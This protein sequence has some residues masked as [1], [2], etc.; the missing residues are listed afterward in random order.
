MRLQVATSAPAIP[1]FMAKRDRSL[2]LSNGVW[3]SFFNQLD[4]YS[5]L[6]DLLQFTCLTLAHLYDFQKVKCKTVHPYKFSDIIDITIESKETN[7]SDYYPREFPY[8][9]NI[10]R[11]N[12]A[13]STIHLK[14]YIKTS[15]PNS[16]ELAFGGYIFQL[17]YQKLINKSLI[18]S[19]EHSF[20]SSRRLLLYAANSYKN[21]HAAQYERRKMEES[22]NLKL[23]QSS[24][25]ANQVKSFASS[26]FERNKKDQRDT[27]YPLGVFTL[28]QKLRINSEYSQHLE[29]ILEN[30]ELANQSAD[31]LFMSHLELSDEKRSMLHSSLNAILG[32][33][34]VA[35]DAN[36]I[37]PSSKVKAKVFRKRKTLSLNWAPICNED[38]EVMNMLVA[39]ED[40]SEA[41]KLKRK[42]GSKKLLLK[43]LK[44]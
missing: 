14:N 39:I 30:H 5:S 2:K 18:K 44:S 32:A 13:A 41:E 42:N 23:A 12:N 27:K 26:L 28:D 25:L 38:D 6:E 9:I 1:I 8:S 37:S 16:L 19:L 36:Q 34:V 31:D 33:H 43:W 24:K 35:Y 4:N 22:F 3:D 15:T 21:R 40:V 7:S 11:I 29:D 10:D 20:Y 17:E